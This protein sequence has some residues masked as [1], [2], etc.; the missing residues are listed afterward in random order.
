MKNYEFEKNDAQFFVLLT[1]DLFSLSL[2]HQKTNRARALLS[3]S[4]PDEGTKRKRTVHP[5]KLNSL[6]SSSSSSASFPS[7]ELTSETSA[8]AVVVNF[9]DG[10]DQATPAASLVVV[11]APVSDSRAASVAAE[12]AAG[13]AARAAG[14][15]A[16]VLVIAALRLDL[17]PS[18]AAA[19]DKE[20]NKGPVV[21][22]SGTGGFGSSSS[23]SSDRTLAADTKIADGFV[24][25]LVLALSLLMPLPSSRPSVPTSSAVSLAAVEGR[26]PAVAPLGSEFDDESSLEAASALGETA[27]SAL[28]LRF[29]KERA[30]RLAPAR[31]ALLEVALPRS[32]SAA[33]AKRH[34]HRPASLLEGAELMYG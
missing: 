10:E 12:I 17:P 13:V 30:A 6:P 22:W 8:P 21:F 23:S 27:A 14:E 32:S 28:K 18:T 15:A 31:A 4:A 19:S 25:A 11:T 1:V 29:S 9:F 3:L 34:E 26:R 2:C 16:E 7:A 20:E 5:I 24:S 33:K